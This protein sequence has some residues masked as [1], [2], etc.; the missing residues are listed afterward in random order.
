[1]R[2]DAMLT[3]WTVKKKE[4]AEILTDLGERGSAFKIYR[5][6]FTQIWII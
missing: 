6:V 2:K 3:D 4:A 5:A 1:M